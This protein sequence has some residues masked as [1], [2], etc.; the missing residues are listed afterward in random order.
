MKRVAA[1]LSL[2]VL[3]GCATGRPGGPML[4]VADEVAILGPGLSC[5]IP[6]PT[7]ALKTANV[8][9][10]IVVHVRGQSFYL[11]AQ[12]QVGPREIDLVALD[13]LG[14]RGLTAKWRADGT[15]NVDRASWLP[16]IVRPADILTEIAVVFW[17]TEA[18]APALSACGITV[19]ETAR[20]RTLSGPKGVLMKVTYKSGTGWTRTARLR[21]APFGID[22]DIQSNDLGS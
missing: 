4:N 16:D 2:L 1:L 3:A 22:I 8:A 9:Q 20:D 21:N 13:G 19:K 14:R 12:I 11:Q 5:A 10:T 18:L 15:L 7:A 17:P 6:R